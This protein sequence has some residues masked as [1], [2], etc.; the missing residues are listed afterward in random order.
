MRQHQAFW[1]VGVPVGVKPRADGM[2]V[3]WKMMVFFQWQDGEK[4]IVWPEELAP[5]KPRFPRRRGASVDRERRCG[6]GPSAL[7]VSVDAACRLHR[8]AASVLSLTG[9]TDR[10]GPTVI[11]SCRETADD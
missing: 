7:A 6:R 10:T 11:S 2:Q 5:V 3:T 9:G 8:P 4:V 1:L